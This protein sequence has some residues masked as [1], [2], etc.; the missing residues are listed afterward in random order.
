MLT[1]TQ[2]INGLMRSMCRHRGTDDEFARRLIL[3]KQLQIGIV[4]R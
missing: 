2:I 3:S 1:V 4:H